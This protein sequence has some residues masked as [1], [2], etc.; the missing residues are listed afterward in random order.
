MSVDP[1]HYL[2]AANGGKPPLLKLQNISAKPELN[3][4]FG[5]A[6][7]FSADRYVVAIL[8]SS[9][10]AAQATSNANIQP[11]FLKLK[12]ENLTEAGNI[13]QL[14]FGASC[15]FATAKA[16]IASPTV[17]T[18]GKDMIR[19]IPPALQSKM[20][21]N[22][23]LLSGAMVALLLLYMLY[24]ILGKIFGAT[25]VFVFLSLTGLILA[26]SSPDWLQGVKANKPIDLI[27]KSSAINFR[28]RW[29]ENLISM[30]GY[31][32]ISDNMALASLVFILLLGGKTLLTSSPSS[33]SKMMPTN[34]A[35]GGG[36]NMQR[37]A[38]SAPQY[39][40]EYIYKLGW[41]DAKA[42]NEFGL[43]LPDD[44]INPEVPLPS[45][46]NQY[47]DNNFDYD[48]YNPPLPPQNKSSGGLGMGTMMSIFALYRFGKDIVTTPDGQVARDPQYIMARLRSI[49]TWRLGMLAMS[50][51]RVVSALSS[52]VR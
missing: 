43:S 48:D 42:G 31:N 12:P 2:P 40:M 26:V 29:K 34:M 49:E 22:K 52:F 25:K 6:V 45:T 8:D 41:E 24:F 30:T 19:K 4:K 28:R 20:T 44:I 5:Q 38:M 10:A 21:P 17:Q 32:N 39:D 11:Q 27:V 3:G 33:S 1:S 46:N 15:L 36:S 23:A 16:Y 13:D 14:K 7:S 35:M 50:L 18:I 9:T 37:S 47:N 51:Y